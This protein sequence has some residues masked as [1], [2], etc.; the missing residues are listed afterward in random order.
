M[1][2]RIVMRRTEQAVQTQGMRLRTR[3][4]GAGMAVVCFGVLAGRLYWLQVVQHDF[5]ARRAANQQLR[6]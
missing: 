6:K 5:Y 1:K 4:L 3:L 2:H